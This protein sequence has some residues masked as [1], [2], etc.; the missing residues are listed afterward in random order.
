MK[1]NGFQSYKTSPTEWP[2]F[3]RGFLF[4]SIHRCVYVSRSVVSNPATPWTVARQAPLSM[5]FSSKNTWVDCHA[6]L[7]EIF[8]TQGSTQVSRITGRFFSIWA[9]RE[10]QFTREQ[11]Q[12]ISLWAEQRHFNLQSGSGTGSSEASMIIITKQWRSSQR[13]SFQHW[14]RIGFLSAT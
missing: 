11:G 4:S 7:Q 13:N 5:E 12:I 10:A 1:W 14:V 8:P 6:L 9:T 2:D 3:G